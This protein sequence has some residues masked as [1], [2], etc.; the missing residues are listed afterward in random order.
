MKYLADSMSSLAGQLNRL[1]KFV[2][3][4]ELGAFISNFDGIMREVVDFIQ[5][6][7]ENW[8]CMCRLLWDESLTESVV[9][10]KSILVAAQTDKAI[11]LRGKIDDFTERFITDV[12]SHIRV[13]QGLVSV[14]ISIV[15]LVWFVIPDA[16]ANLV[17][18]IQGGLSAT[19]G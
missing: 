15:Q 10:V 1:K 9:P 4:D 12:L 2:K 6:W 13:E 16:I 18:N 7:L 14:P 5:K 11:E 8:S 3:S 19:P 17:A